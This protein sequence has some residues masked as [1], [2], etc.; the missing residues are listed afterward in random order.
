MSQS[1]SFCKQE[2]QLLPRDRAMRNVNSNLNPNR[3]PNPNPNHTKRNL[4]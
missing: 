4:M 1:V 2:A 3:Y